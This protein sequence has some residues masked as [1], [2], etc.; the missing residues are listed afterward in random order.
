MS[1]K[2]IAFLEQ[3]DKR[4]T[5]QKALLLTIILTLCLF[6]IG[7][8]FAVGQTASKNFTKIQNQKEDYIEFKI[9]VATIKKDM[10]DAMMF[11]ELMESYAVQSQI[12]LSIKN[13]DTK[14]IEEV[15]KLFNKWR[16]EKLFDLEDFNRRSGEPISDPHK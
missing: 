6:L 14:T 15:Q 5:R 11:K 1:E 3:I 12:M 7:G 2:E 10:V 13:G 4:Y 16:V 8:Y 9:E